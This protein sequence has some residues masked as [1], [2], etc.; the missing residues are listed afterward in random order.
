[1]NRPVTLMHVERI[2]TGQLELSIHITGEHAA[3]MRLRLA[4]LL[5]QGEAGMWHGIA[6]E[7]QAVAIKAPCSR[8]I[9]QEACR[10]QSS[11][12]WRHPSSA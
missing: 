4:P 2:K 12:L 3:A 1:M 6:V 8:R 5:Y 10:C 7:R 9:A 11:A